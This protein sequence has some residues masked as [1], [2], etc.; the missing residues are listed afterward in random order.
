MIKRSIFTN[1]S[2]IIITIYIFN[3]YRDIDEAGNS[4]SKMSNNYAK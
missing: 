4:I 2:V 3:K 1:L